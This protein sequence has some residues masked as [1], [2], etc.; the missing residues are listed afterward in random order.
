M[1]QFVWEAGEV[2][3]VVAEVSFEDEFGYRSHARSF[4]VLSSE[5]CNTVFL[6]IISASVL[7][8]Y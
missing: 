4:L 5:V 2:V 1:L 6:V 3:Q 8:R 7:L